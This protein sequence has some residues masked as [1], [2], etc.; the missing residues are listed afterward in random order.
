VLYLAFAAFLGYV[1][2]AH[3]EA[4][5]CGCA[6]PTP[7]PPSRLHLGLN[8]VAAVASFAYA[9][10]VAPPVWTWLVSMGWMSLPVIAGLTVAGWLAVI[11]VTLTPAAFRSWTPPA[12]DHEAEPHGHDHA[13]AD[14]QLESAGVMPG[15]A[16]L[17]PGTKD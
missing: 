8:V 4:G 1:L 11:V 14:R 6:G 17:W 2:V 13:V 15:H 9:A 3:P 16:S 5:S 7:V 12:H 10:T